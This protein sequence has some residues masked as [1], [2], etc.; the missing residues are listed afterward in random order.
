MIKLK[1]IEEPVLLPNPAN[2]WESGAV[3]NP[4]TVREGEMVHLLYR[5]VEG[6]NFSAIGYARFDRNHNLLER[7]NEPVISRIKL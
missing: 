3:F 5:A 1:R 2:R 6:E 4:G 7:R